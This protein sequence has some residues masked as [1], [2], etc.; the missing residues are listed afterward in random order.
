M[1]GEFC[2]CPF[3]GISTETELADDDCGTVGYVERDGQ[4]FHDQSCLRDY[5]DQFTGTTLKDRFDRARIQIAVVTILANTNLISLDVT[6][7]IEELGVTPANVRALATP[8][9]PVAV[10][11][12]G[13]ADSG[14]YYMDIGIIPQQTFDVHVTVLVFEVV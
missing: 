1:S 3:C 10:A 7:R 14:K 8:D 13:R 12:N 2:V 9:Y 11:V 5:L 4:W 6:D